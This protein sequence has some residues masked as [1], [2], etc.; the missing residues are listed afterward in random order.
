MTEVLEQAVWPQLETDLDHAN[1]LGGPGWLKD[2]RTANASRVATLGFPVYTQENWRFTNITPILKSD[3]RSI[4]APPQSEVAAEAIAPLLYDAAWPALVMV[5]GRFSPT[6]STTNG[7]P[8]GVVAGSLADAIASGNAAAQANLDQHA[9]VRDGFAAA[10][11]AF[12]QDGVF[13]HVPDGVAVETPIHIVVLST[14]GAPRAAHPRILVVL[15][16]SAEVTTVESYTALRGDT[17]DFSNLVSEFVLGDDAKLKRHKVIEEGARGYHLESAWVSQARDASLETF[18]MTLTGQIVRS[19]LNVL[20]DGPGAQAKLNG[21]YLNDGDRLTDNFL[22]VTH[23][24]PNCYSRMAYK[25]VL[26]GTS[27]AV[28]TGKV[29]VKPEGQK[30]DSNQL[31]NNLLLSD[32]ATI[33]TKPQ[34]EI[35]ADD[36]K[37]THGATIGGFPRELRFYFQSRGMTDAMAQAILTYGFASEIVGDIGVDAL[38][39]RLSRYVFDKYSPAS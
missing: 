9:D 16:E 29:W 37:C 1:A 26:D 8:N 22:H 34:L 6:L 35:F 19:E 12:L 15:G 3:F 14:A 30:T 20:L 23:A 4:L 32:A 24:A 11:G 21:L 33:D 13:I 17:A 36:V 39:A 38:R 28:F 7:F 10:N 25:G 31:N 5:D 2:L 18:A 27:A